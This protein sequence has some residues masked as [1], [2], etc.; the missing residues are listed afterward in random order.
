MNIEISDWQ[1]ICE[2]EQRIESKS[3]FRA[4]NGKLWPRFCP[5][6][7]GAITEYTVEINYTPKELAVFNFEQWRRI[8]KD[9]K[10]EAGLY[11]PDIPFRE[12]GRFYFVRCDNYYSEIVKC[13]V[14]NHEWHKDL[15][16]AR[17][18][19]FSEADEARRT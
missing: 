16:S 13:P 14:L 15:E 17:A 3:I 4:K 19:F 11:L 5:C 9:L 10:D 2:L 8:T 6:C 18:D 1:L 12:T 7:G